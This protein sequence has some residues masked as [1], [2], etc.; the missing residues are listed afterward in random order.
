[1]FRNLSVMRVDSRFNIPQ[2]RYHREKNDSKM[3]HKMENSCI[4]VSHCTCVE[5]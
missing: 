3:L 2:Q 4:C 5:M 1:M